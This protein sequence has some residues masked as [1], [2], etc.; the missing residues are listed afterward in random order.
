MIQYGKLMASSL[1]AEKI[2]KYLVGKKHFLHRVLETI[3]HHLLVSR[4]CNLRQDCVA[5]CLKYLILTVFSKCITQKTSDF[6]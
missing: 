5:N 2:P 1:S 4:I 3:T 6:L